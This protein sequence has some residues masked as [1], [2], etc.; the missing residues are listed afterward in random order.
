M[1]PTSFDELRPGTYDVRE[2]VLDMS[3]N[4]R[5]RLAQL[6]VAARA[7]RAGSSRR[8][9]TRTPRSRL[10]RAYNDWHIE[11]WCGYAP[12]RFIPLAIPPIWDPDAIA[13]EVRRVAKKGCHAITFPEN[14]VP[15]GLPSLHSDHW[16][17]FWQACNDEGTVV[18]MHIGSSAKLA[19]TAPDA[20]IDVLITLQPMNIVQAAADLS[21]RRCS[22]SSPTSPIALSEGGI[23]WIPYFLER[24][25]HTYKAH[26]AWT[27]ADFGDKLPSEVF[28]ERMILC[29]IED[30]FGARQ[31]RE[32]GTDRICIETDYPHSDA[33][34]PNAPERMMEAF[35]PHRSHRRRDQPD[36]PPQR[37]EVLPATTRS[38]SARARSAP[39]AR[40][41]PRRPGTTSRSWPKG[42]RIEHDEPTKVAGSSRRVRD[43]TTFGTTAKFWDADADE[44][45]AAHGDELRERPLA[46]GAYRIPE[47]GARRPR[48]RRGQGRARARLRRRAVVDRARRRIGARCV[49]LDLSRAQLAHARRAAATLPLVQA[50]GEQLPFADASFDVV[51]C[52]HG[53]ISFCDPTLIIPEA[54]R[55]LRPRRAARVLRRRTRCSISRGTREAS[56]ADAPAAARL[57]RPRPH[58]VRRRHDR[59]GAPGRASGSDVLRAQ[60]LRRSR[61]S[62]SSARRPT[63]TTTYEE[64]APPKWARRWPAEWIWKT[65][66]ASR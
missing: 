16:D 32:I 33:V 42:R 11:E 49:G 19:I 51:F 12:E 30:D 7:S 41:A 10:C 57:R 6:P 28:M 63:L 62:S 40:C 65:R 1:D 14:P 5:A 9:T 43:A 20:P 53:A 61:T 66:R 26:K 54:A 36:H 29:F 35:A 17:P 18:C 27:F 25:D 4:G 24:I 21:S 38:R 13:D 46:W 59:L 15:L 47:V 64:F 22:A 2:R 56:N 8:S 60:R 48:R 55:V 52:D 44:Y 3:A 58:G 45:Q 23:G 50:S 39:S 37:D 31:A 34:W